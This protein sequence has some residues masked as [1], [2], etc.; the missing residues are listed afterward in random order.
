MTEHERISEL[1]EAHSLRALEP[2]EAR[3]VERHV[4]DCVDCRRRLQEYEA[5]A[6]ELPAALSRSSPL[7]LHPSLKERVM[8]HV[9][10]PAR[11][12]LAGAARWRALALAACLLLAA[13]VFWNW[14]QARELAHERQVRIELVGKISHD[15]GIVFDVVD[16][17]VTSKHVLRSPTD[18]G[19][20]APYGKI[21]S[22]SDS[23]DVVAMVNRLARP[24]DGSAYTLWVEDRGVVTEAGTF[25][26][27]Q[28]GF[29]Y[30]V[31]RAPRIGPVYSHVEVRLGE[32]VMLQYTSS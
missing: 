32:R 18:S 3:R 23:A 21:F 22:R 7:R 5:A 2:G 28:D 4:R 10:A 13:S 12:W 1:L 9:D 31:F 15:Q 14:E 26:L 8:R 19:P 24:P 11:R 30:V 20:A 6:A 29:G 16:S 25:A 27:D 17:P